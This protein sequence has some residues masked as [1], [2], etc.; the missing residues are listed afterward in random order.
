MPTHVLYTSDGMHLAR[1]ATLLAEGKRD[2]FDWLWPS[3]EAVA[4]TYLA[5]NALDSLWN[6]AATRKDTVATGYLPTLAGR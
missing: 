3:K 1:A 2:M 6:A 5:A 4:I